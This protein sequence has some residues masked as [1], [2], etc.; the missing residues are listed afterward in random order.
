MDPCFSGACESVLGNIQGGAAAPNQC[1]RSSEIAV[2]IY[3]ERLRCVVSNSAVTL[4]SCLK[5]SDEAEW[6]FEPA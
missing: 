2:K 1:S 6:E 3:L 4:R 5:I